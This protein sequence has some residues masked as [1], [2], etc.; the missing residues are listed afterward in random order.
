MGLWCSSRQRTASSSRK[1]LPVSA[2]QLHHRLRQGPHALERGSD[3]LTERPCLAHQRADL[4]RDRVQ[5]LHFLPREGDRLL[6][7][8]D[9]YA[10]DHAAVDQRHAQEGMVVFLAGLAKELE[11]RVPGGVLDHQRPELLGHQAGQPLVQAHADLADAFR[12][13]ADR[14]P[15]HQMGPI[16][17]DQVQ[18]ADIDLEEFLNR[19]NN[20]REDLLGP[21]FQGSEGQDLVTRQG[22]RGVRSGRWRSHG[23]FPTGGRSG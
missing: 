7:L 1:R 5:R 17:L 2:S 21:G 3:E 4:V 19:L 18:G 16:G 10:L 15:Q 22:A 11:T 13:Q 8:D 12:T 9:Q 6:T 14:R 20:A 23:R